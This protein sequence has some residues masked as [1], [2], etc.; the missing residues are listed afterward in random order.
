MP[1]AHGGI[2]LSA[3]KNVPLVADG[4][5]RK[6]KYASASL[7]DRTMNLSAHMSGKSL[8][9]KLT[10]CVCLNTWNVF[11]LVHVHIM[12][13]VVLEAVNFYTCLPLYRV[14]H[15]ELCILY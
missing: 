7:W 5:R 13:C 3:S 14:A 11:L 12:L 1:W 15:R 2:P 8:P 6:H 4:G 10:M 9:S